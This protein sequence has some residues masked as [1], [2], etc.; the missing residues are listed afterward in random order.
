MENSNAPFQLACIQTTT[1]CHPQS[2]LEQLEKL[3]EQA[4]IAGASYV[5]TPETSNFMAENAEKMK[6]MV[7]PEDADICVTG[8]AGLA[9]KHNI[10]LQAGS[11][12]LLNET[13]VPVNRSLM[14]SPKGEIVAR[15]D[16]IHLFDATLPNGETHQ[17]SANY[18]AG[19]KAVAFD[20]PLGCVGMSICYDVR[21]PALYQALAQAGAIYLTIPAAF[22]RATG[23]AHWEILLRARAIETGSYVFASAQCGLH[24]NDRKTYGHSMIIDPWG[25]VLADGGKKIGVITADIDPLKVKQARCRLPVLDHASDF[26]SGAPDSVPEE[27]AHD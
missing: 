26:D 24:E 9:Q 1:R 25:K 5:L 16:K 7:K 11:F 14:F 17:E 18:Q 4:V 10:W 21:F 8:F 12:I 13:G 19:N 3:I 15:Y 23:E 22:T 27:A 2:N 6:Q 20:F